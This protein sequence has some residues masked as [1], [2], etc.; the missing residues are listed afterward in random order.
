[1]VKMPEL[2]KTMA[3]MAREMERAGLIEGVISDTLG[4]LDVIL[5]RFVYL[6]VD[7]QLT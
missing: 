7:T 1:M 6:I 3:A 2:N 5:S 4:M